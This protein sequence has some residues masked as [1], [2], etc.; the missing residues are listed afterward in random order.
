MEN[1]KRAKI[2]PHVIL[3]GIAA[4]LLIITVVRLIIWNIGVKVEYDP[5]ED[6]SQFDTDPQDY[7]Q[8]MTADQLEGHEDDGI[9]TIL[10]L[11]NGAFADD[12]GEDGLASIIAKEAD[13]VTYDCSFAGSC[14]SMKN[15]AYDASYPMDAYSLYQ[16][17]NAL[18]TGDFS[19]QEQVLAA[20]ESKAAQE[21]LEKLKNLDMSK[22][23]VLT[24]MY[25]ISDYIS[26]RPV[27]DPNNDYNLVTCYG[28]MNAAIKQFQ[29]AYPYVRVVVL[30]IPYGEFDDGTG[31]MIDGDTTDFGNGTLVD[32]LLAEIDAAMHNGASVLDN[33]YGTIMESRKEEYLTEGFHMNKAGRTAVA[34]RLAAILE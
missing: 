28:A 19:L 22:V 6:T 16:V 27:Y 13:A 20:S 24:I 10:C 5:N 12:R 3:L 30:S 29:E 14:I 8:M 18:T 23:D 17:V 11:G 32:Y 2:N 15:A 1:K 31:N 4:L 21:P 33:Y 7:I 34:K 25:D 26:L 9:T